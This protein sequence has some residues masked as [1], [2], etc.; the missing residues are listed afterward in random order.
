[1]RSLGIAVMFVSLVA[2]CPAA[3]AQTTRPA[4]A[5]ATRPAGNLPFLDIDIPNRILRVECLAVKADYALE[6]YCVKQGTNEYEAILSS[7]VTPS[8]LHLA[9]LM[10]GLEPGQA[11]RYSKATES[12]LPPQGPALRLSVEWMKD[13]KLVRYPAYR[14]LR[15]LKTK[16]EAAP[17]TWIFA[18]SRHS[19]NGAYVADLTGY[20]VSVTNVDGMVI[21]LPERVSNSMDERLWEPNWDLMPEAGTK[22]WLV[23]EPEGARVPATQPAAAKTEPGGT[24]SSPPKNRE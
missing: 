21:D 6:F 15:N 2:L 5:P 18:G 10:V 11:L 19:E 7:K 17:M 23:I 9:L 13:G 24:R 12:W 1:M 4:P 22:T 3:G 14:L 8:H 20:L 16:K